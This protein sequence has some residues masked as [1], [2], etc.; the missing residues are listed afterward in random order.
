MRSLSRREFLAG[1]TSCAAHLALFASIARPGI[2]AAWHR[3]A[4]ERVAAREP[5]GRLEEVAQGVWALISTPL[6]G[7]RTTLANGG[8]IAG[9][10]GVLAIEGFYQTAGAAWL[11]GKSRELTGRWPT[12]VALTH[13]HADHTNGVAGYVAEDAHPVIRAT[14]VTRA[15]VLSR[16]PPA[17]PARTAA[18]EGAELLPRAEPESLDLGDRVVRVIPYAGHTDSDVVI[19]LDEPSVVFCGDL[20][21]N[22]MFPNYV[23]AMPARLSA[24]VRQLR[25]EKET[26]YVPGHGPLADAVEFDRYVALLDAVEGAA[27][28]AHEQGLSADVAAAEFAIPTELG[29]WTLFGRTF[30]Q[31]AFAAWYGELDQ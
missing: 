8:L 11:G 18:L 15:L 13:Y 31:R 29:D 22:G 27:R 9:K 20:V 4:R 10:D 24:A 7:D 28:H 19:E 2:R 5:F 21:W 25:R 30:F 23:D 12:H 17:E 16:N 14:E 3:A 1:A 6:D 26:V